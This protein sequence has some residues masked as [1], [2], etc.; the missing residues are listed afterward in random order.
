MKSI[1][2]NNIFIEFN[3]YTASSI[4]RKS[5]SYLLTYSTYTST[6]LSLLFLFFKILFSKGTLG[7]LKTY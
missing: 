2:K 3:N 7:A 6:R 4:E 5:I 1:D